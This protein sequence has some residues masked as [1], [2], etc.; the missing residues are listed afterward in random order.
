MTVGHL[1]FAVVTTAFIL[2]SIPLE[3]RDLAN[4]HSEYD[5]YK[6]RVPMLFP[7]GRKEPADAPEAST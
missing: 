1:F 2:W 6:K 4:G 3:E 7:T 5:A